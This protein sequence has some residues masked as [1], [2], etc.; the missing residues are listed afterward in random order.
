MSDNL[1]PAGVKMEK[2]LPSGWRQRGDQCWAWVVVPGHVL[3]VLALVGPV[4]DSF[5]R[6]MPGRWDAVILFGVTVVV[7]GIVLMF[8]CWLLACT[9][10]GGER[11]ADPDGRDPETLRLARRRATVLVLVDA[12]VVFL[13]V[14]AGL[15][16]APATRGMFRSITSPDGQVTWTNSGLM[17]RVRQ[18]VGERSL[19]RG[20]LVILLASGVLSHRPLTHVL[21]RRHQRTRGKQSQGTT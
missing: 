5:S 2:D 8:G 13:A 7:A 10:R 17:D 12:I 4:A 14:V 19:I 18:A 6:R 21:A 15:H 11:V 20:F 9:R 1:R 3:T 16:L